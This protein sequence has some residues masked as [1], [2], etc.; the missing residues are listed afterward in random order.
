MAE[1]A[2]AAEVPA[3]AAEAVG[4]VAMVAASAEA[5]VTVVEIGAVAAKLCSRNFRH[6]GCS[7]QG[8]VSTEQ[9]TRCDCQPCGHGG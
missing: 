7:D 5:H 2:A 8:T 3:T 4:T 9:G 6:R 1:V